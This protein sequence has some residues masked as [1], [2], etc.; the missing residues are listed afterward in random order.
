V[1]QRL[2]RLQLL[3]KASDIEKITTAKVAVV[4][5][6]GVGGPALEC[7][8]R[9]GIRH[10][11]LIDSDI[12]QSSNLNRQTLYD[13]SNLGMKKVSA[14]KNR[15]QAI[16]PDLDI[17]TS[18]VSITMESITI[19]DEYQPDYVIDAIDSIIGKCALI[20]WAI[21]HQIPFV[22][23]LGM[24]NRINPLAI[25]LTTLAKTSSDPLAKALRTELRKQKIDID[26]VPVVFSS[27]APVRKQK[28]VGSYMAVTASAGLLLAHYIVATIL[29]R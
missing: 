2:K 7:L 28:P 29:E 3:F 21:K 26:Q 18:D 10:F 5:L 11:L 24:G 19:L 20:N 23:S 9:S 17:I 12:V 27:E 22:S 13:I 6:G 4:G 15:I 25:T 1:E 8:V 14:A 16:A